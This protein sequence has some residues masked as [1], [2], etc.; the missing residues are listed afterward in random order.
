MSCNLF[1]LVALLSLDGHQV[2]EHCA[3][4]FKGE[5]LALAH[6]VSLLFLIVGFLLRGL[7]ILVL[8]FA[9]KHLQV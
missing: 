3:I 4:S 8:H 2:V 1:V 6:Q 5:P 9:F 7:P